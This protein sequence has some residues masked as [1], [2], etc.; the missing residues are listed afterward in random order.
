[1]KKC[2]MIGGILLLCIIVFFVGRVYETFQDDPLAHAVYALKKTGLSQEYAPA[3]SL[4]GSIGI[5]DYFSQTKFVVQ[6]EHERNKL[7]QEASL[8]KGWHTAP[9]TAEEYL[10]FQETCM[11]GYETLDVPDDVVFDAWYYLETHDPLSYSASAPEGG[12][13]EIGQVGYGYEFAVFD[14]ESGLFIFVDLFG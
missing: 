2:L 13:K 12:L 4:H 8:T 7:L 14:V 11:W 6:Y 10:C 3:Y 5:R 9:V 1:M